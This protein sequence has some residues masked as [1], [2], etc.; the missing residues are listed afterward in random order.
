[1]LTEKL[2]QMNY[3][4]RVILMEHPNQNPEWKYLPKGVKVYVADIRLSDDQSKKAMAEAC[5]NVSIIFHLAAST[6]NYNNRYNDLI[7]TNVIGTENIIKAYF[8]A[9]ADS[10]MK[11]HFIYTSSIAIYGYKR[12]DETLT[13]ESEPMPRS[14]YSE[15]KYMAEQVIKAFATA[16]KR[17]NYT[18]FRIGV[19]YGKRYEYNFFRIFKRIK[20]QTLRYIGNGEN[21]LTLINVDDVVKALLI[22]MENSKSIN[23]IYNL[24][25]GV[26]YTQKELFK[27]AAKFLN[28]EA[29]TEN[30]HPF[31]ARVIARHR[32]INLDQLR[33]LVSDRIV[34]I[35]KIKKE[36]GFKPSVSIDIAGKVLAQEFLKKHSNL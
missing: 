34:S 23:K 18:I 27:K 9:N 16:N 22:P 7:N 3:E 19:I 24:T 2:L 13:E 21:H 14:A 15:S 6:S 25:D 5:K 32:E 10:D 12:K 1:L 36:L 4:V 35:D 11:M 31:L 17:L 30:I 33:F 28:V 29:P 20:E 8:D 26:P